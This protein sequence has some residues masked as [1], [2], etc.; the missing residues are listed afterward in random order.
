MRSTALK[1]LLVAVAAAS[2]AFPAAAREFADAGGEHGYARLDW[3]LVER[4]IKNWGGLPALTASQSVNTAACI[5]PGDKDPLDVVVRRT[6]ALIADLSAA[7]VDLSAETR[8]LDNIARRASPRSPS[9]TPS[10]GA[11]P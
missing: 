11:S 7:G 2:L 6:R 10:T 3:D 9:Y 4:D 1:D 8:E 5:L